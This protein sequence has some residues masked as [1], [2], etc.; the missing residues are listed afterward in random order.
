MAGG[1]WAS[2]APRALRFTVSSIGMFVLAVDHS[3]IG[4]GFPRARSKSDL[5]R[6]AD[7]GVRLPGSRPA[8]P[9]APATGHLALRVDVLVAVRRRVGPAPTASRQEQ[10]S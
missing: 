7:S 2:D 3:T 4:L 10:T 9:P 6:L 1:R 5:E 8:E